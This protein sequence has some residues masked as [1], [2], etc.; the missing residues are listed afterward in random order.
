MGSADRVGK[1]IDRLHSAD[2][3]EV[4]P[5]LN[6]NEVKALVN[7]LFS[8]NRAAQTLR[9]LPKEFL[10]DVLEHLDEPMV[11]GIVE[12]LAPDDA[13]TFIALLEEEK[14]SKIMNRLSEGK[15]EQIEHHLTYPP[16]S[17]GTVMTT[18][19]FALPGHLTAQDAIGEV[20]RIGDRLES[21][22]YLYVTDEQGHLLGVVPIR[23]L[24][25]GAPERTLKEIMIPDPANI[26]VDA[27]REKAAEIIARFN[28]LAIPV[29]DEN[30]R[31]LGIITVDD[32]IDIIQE[33]ATEDMYR[34]AGLSAKDRIFSPIHRSIWNR[35][36]WMILN[37]LTVFLSVLVIGLFEDSIK[38]VAALAI[39]MPIVAA[40]GGNA[41][42]Q[43][44]TV[45]TRGIA[46]GELK[47]SSGVEIVFRQIGIG[48]VIGAFTGLLTSG[49][50]YLWKGNPYLGLILFA[51]MIVNMGV[52]GLTGAAV[53]LLLRAIGQDPALGGSIFTI[54]FTDFFGFLTF[55]GLA[56]LFI[57]Y[58]M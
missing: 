56:T 16:D 57:S 53:P 54:T 58:L 37:L 47:F 1:F 38:K 21:I 35:L 18:E 50:V 10:A 36:P 19:F 4:F 51:A 41:G 14:R 17:A 43:T 11:A 25:A 23:R 48:L 49:V 28:L 32:V 46:L 24:V 12:R 52:A 8:E 31:L 9:E 29:V 5:E 45:V 30:H 55:L 34:I 39:F 20:R 2:L 6:I 13:V 42:T 15:R 27:D 7:I 33:E 22:F 3:G 26:E 40:M 44:L